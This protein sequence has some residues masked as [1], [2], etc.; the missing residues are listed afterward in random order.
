MHELTLGLKPFTVQA[1]YLIL[2][3]VLVYLFMSLVAQEVDKEV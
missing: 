1:L 3:V 2:F